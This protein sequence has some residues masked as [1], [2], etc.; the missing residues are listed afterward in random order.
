MSNR[1]RNRRTVRVN[2]EHAISHVPKVTMCVAVF[3]CGRP[4]GTF[5]LNN[6]TLVN[7][8]T[9]KFRIAPSSGS[10]RK[11]TARCSVHSTLHGSE[12]NFL[13]CFID[14][15]VV[16]RHVV[17]ESSAST[18]SRHNLLVEGMPP[19]FDLQSAG[20]ELKDALLSTNCCGK[21][22]W[23]KYPRHQP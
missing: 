19:V 17:V 8:F 11:D 22:H 10:M 20:R 2:C 4:R 23:V 14:G 13:S 15:N 21:R 5:G 6:S 7:V 9:F 1:R 18:T 3:F 16:R 12:G